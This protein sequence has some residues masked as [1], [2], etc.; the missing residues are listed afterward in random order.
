MIHNIKGIYHDPTAGAIRVVLHDNTSLNGVNETRPACLRPYLIAR[1]S[2]PAVGLVEQWFYGQI[3]STTNF[4]EGYYHV[5]TPGLYFL[6]IIL[7]LCNTYDDDLLRQAHRHVTGHCSDEA[8]AAFAQE[9]LYT[10]Q[11]C[12]VR[13]D[14]HRLTRSNTSM[15][16]DVRAVSASLD[17]RRL[18]G[19][20]EGELNP[21]QK[22]HGFWKRN[23]RFAQQ[24]NG[25]DQTLYTRYSPYTCPV[26][27]DDSSDGA[28][29]KSGGNGSKS[30]DDS[31]ES[32]DDT[33]VS[34]DNILECSR[35]REPYRFSWT[36]GEGDSQR[37]VDKK[38]VADKVRMKSEERRNDTF[39]LVR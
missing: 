17:K 35:Q 19:R 26:F 7:I 20:G 11:F 3:D 23:T 5:P 32:D 30:D 33:P 36:L 2:G 34:V 10:R 38:Y 25:T 14:N 22:L 21:L 15:V 9:R 31:S 39:L 18:R 1:L 28:A 13:T 16:V 29:S 4:V 6:E 8:T 24:P 37:M 12:P 27:D